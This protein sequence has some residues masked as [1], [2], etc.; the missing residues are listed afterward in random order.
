M[1]KLKFKIVL[2][3]FF[4]LVVIFG[5]RFII[6]DSIYAQC[7]PTDADEYCRQYNDLQ[8][9]LDALSPAQERNKAELEK[10]KNDLEKI[11]KGLIAVENKLKINEKEIFEREVNLGVQRELLDARIRELYKKSR[12]FSPLSLFLSSGTV[13]SFTH[14]LGLRQATAKE[15]LKIILSLSKEITDL[16]EA[17]RKL[18]SNQASL[19]SLKVQID[20][21]AEFLGKEV[22]K[23]EGA[24]A[25]IKAKQQELLALKAAG[26]Q[27]SVGD[28]PPADDPASRPDYNPGFSPAFAAFSFGAPHR[29]GMSQFG[30]YGRAKA[31]QNTEQILKAYY[32]GGI[33]IKKDY[34]TNINIQVQGYGTVDLETYVKRIYEVPNSWGESGFEAL[35]AQAIAARSYA[36][37]YTNNGSGSICA[38]ENCQ[39]YKPANKGGK[40][41][42]AVNATRGWVLMA[43][44][45]PFSSWYASTAGGYIFSYTYSGYSTPGFWDTSSGKEGWP[46]QAWEKVAGSPWFYK[47]WYRTRGGNSYG[48]SHPWLNED[49]FTD[50]LNAL[51]IY[52]GNPGEVSHLSSLDAKIADTWSRGK[53]REEAAKYNGPVTKVN[54]LGQIYSNDGYTKLVYCETDKGRKEF[55]GEEFKYI[56]NLRA[57]GAIGIKSSLFDIRKK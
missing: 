13:G 46:D 27:T 40:W 36:L 50:V 43:G 7:A 15:D 44:G 54:S 57:P 3:T 8:K 31:G 32:G 28:V 6:Q 56:F 14:E 49:E 2:V 10:F 25:Q 19:A 26:F 51:L 17:K 35:K 21:K 34:P 22:E 29:K 24:F 16:E 47:S 1:S 37:A 38:T 11:K 48:R 33:E 9:L 45:R 5:S 18:R 23:T 4:L 39:V 53:V 12:S 52:K 55:S 20:Q 41:E 42:E 30:A